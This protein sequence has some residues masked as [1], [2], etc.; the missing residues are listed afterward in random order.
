MDESFKQRDLGR[1]VVPEERLEAARMIGFEEEIE[2]EIS[3]TEEVK[4]S[5]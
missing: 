3:E 1:A 2:S 4:L 5:P